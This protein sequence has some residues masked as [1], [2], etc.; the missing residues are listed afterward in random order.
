MRFLPHT[1]PPQGPI[2][3]SDL[4]SC[5]QRC[6]G[7][8]LRPQNYGFYS[9]GELLEAAAD[10]IYKHQTRLGS[11][12]S[13]REHRLS[14]ELPIPFTKPRKTGQ[15]NSVPVRADR[16]THML[17]TRPKLTVKSQGIVVT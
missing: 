1:I 6:F 3:T 17:D 8:P 12:V 7:Y 9:T 5:F 14:S 11:A 16:N 2:L 4:E 10:L 15:I 13:L